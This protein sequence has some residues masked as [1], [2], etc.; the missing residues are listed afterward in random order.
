MP[1]KTPPKF[2]CASIPEDAHDAKLLGLYPQKQEGALMQRVKALGGRLS[3]GQWDTLASLAG[4]YTPDTPLHL[5]TRQS[6]EFHFLSSDKIPVVQKKLSESGL[7]GFASAGDTVRNV[8]LASE[9]GWRKGTYDMFPLAELIDKTVAG[10]PWVYGMPRK[11]KISLSGSTEG[12]ARPYMSDLGFIAKDDGTF[13]VVV[14]GSLGAKP[15]LGISFCDSLNLSEVLPLI[16]AA[17][18]LFDAEGDRKVRTRA[19]LRHVRERMGGEEFL[20]KLNELF[21]EEKG[22]NYPVPAAPVMAQADKAFIRLALPNGNI[23]ADSLRALVEACKSSG[24]EIRAGLEH[25]LYVSKVE[26][27]KVPAEL[28]AVVDKHRVI[29]CPGAHWCAK[30]IVNTWPM[31]E[32]ILKAMPEGSDKLVA[33]SGCPNNCAHAAIASVGMTGCIKTVDGE[34]VEHFRVYLG[35]GQGCNDKLAKEAEGPVDFDGA[36]ELAKR[37]LSED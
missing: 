17:L 25:D 7:S 18:R 9:D 32:E 34:R 15:G 27:A 37:E 19:R 20:A 8:T 12:R 36:V 33:I 13:M 24:G 29:T 28:A 11:F 4:E 35:G 6:V 16:V 2:P 10:I 23:S 31:A 22:N 14:A 5:T 21:A 30:G 1:E 26:A 3:L